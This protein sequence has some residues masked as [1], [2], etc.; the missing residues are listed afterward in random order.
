MRSLW[1]RSTKHVVS[2]YICFRLLIFAKM[3]KLKTLCFLWYTENPWFFKCLAFFP[4]K[5]AAGIWLYLY[6]THY[7][8]RLVGFYEYAVPL[9]P[10]G[11]HTL[12]IISSPPIFCWLCQSRLWGCVFIFDQLRSVALSV[13]QGSSE[14]SRS[15]AVCHCEGGSCCNQS[16]CHRC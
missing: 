3:H 14:S 6:I 13:W 9:S 8:I 11:S 4:D 1:G 15:I 12:I 2:R 5:A 10:T 16:C 7:K